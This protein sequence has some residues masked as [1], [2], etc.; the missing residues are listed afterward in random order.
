ME[1]WFLWDGYEYEW[2]IDEGAT[3]FVLGD[4]IQYPNF[5]EEFGEAAPPDIA[6]YAPPF[7][8]R[9]NDQDTL[10]IWPGIVARSSEGIAAHVR[11]PVNFEYGRGFVVIEG[12]IET[13]WWFGPLLVNLK[14]QKKGKPVVLRRD[15]PLLQ[16]VPFSKKVYEQFESSDESTKSGLQALDQD[17]WRAYRDTVVRRMQTRTRLG[18]YAVD[19]RRRRSR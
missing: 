13:D 2:S 12:V 18:D 3:W 9:T 14:F 16:V 17:E 19:A 6:E 7:A 5:L 4:S 10:Q 1:I 15:K 8:S 11:A